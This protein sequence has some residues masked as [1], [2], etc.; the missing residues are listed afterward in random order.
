[1][2][3]LAAGDLP[4]QRIRK[5]FRNAWKLSVVSDFNDGLIFELEYWL[6]L[7]ARC[8]R[9]SG[10]RI[11]VLALPAHDVRVVWLLFGAGGGSFRR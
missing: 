5:H 2:E 8:F 9:C 1:M 6:A 7:Y 11:V 10:L 4:K 3:Y